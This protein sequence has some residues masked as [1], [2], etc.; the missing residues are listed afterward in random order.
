MGLIHNLCDAP[1]THDVSKTQTWH[2]KMGKRPFPTLAEAA[3]FGSPCQTLEQSF[4]LDPLK[5]F[6]LQS[7][8]FDVCT[9]V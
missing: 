8:Q 3:A 5:S 7:Q 4:V 1:E 9:F 6:G 2:K